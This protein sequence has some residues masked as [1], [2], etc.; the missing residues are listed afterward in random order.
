MKI[1]QDFFYKKGI[2]S[3]FFYLWTL[4]ISLDHS[5]YKREM[6]QAVSSWK[7]NLREL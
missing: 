3:I 7:M 5:L 4:N 1:I 6:R 2:K